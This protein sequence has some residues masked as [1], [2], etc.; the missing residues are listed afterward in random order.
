M[1]IQ[2]VDLQNKSQVRHLSNF[3]TFTIVAVLNGY[4]LSG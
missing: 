2:R 3:P 4:L 1:L